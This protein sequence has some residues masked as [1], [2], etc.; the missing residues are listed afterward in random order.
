M[1]IAGLREKTAVAVAIQ[2]AARQRLRY[3]KYGKKTM[4]M[5]FVAAATAR[6]TP[7]AAFFPSDC[8]YSPQR[9]TVKRMILICS[10]SK[11][12]MVNGSANRKGTSNSGD[13]S[14]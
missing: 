10:N 9:A 13:V 4:A 5:T 7:P 1:K 12:L 8:K 14:V 2:K 3:T 6:R 11:L